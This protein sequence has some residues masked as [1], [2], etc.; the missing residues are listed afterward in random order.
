MDVLAIRA[1]WVLQ[2]EHNTLDS[3][4]A[5]EVVGVGRPARVRARPIASDGQP[6]VRKLWTNCLADDKEAS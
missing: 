3:R 5:A 6:A 2:R 1:A 4:A